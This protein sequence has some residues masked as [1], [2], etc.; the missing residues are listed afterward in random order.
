MYQ[1]LF[2]YATNSCEKSTEAYREIGAQ[3][4]SFI[5]HN[6][7]AVVL[8]AGTS[9]VSKG[10]NIDANTKHYMNFKHSHVLKEANV[11]RDK[12]ET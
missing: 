5:Y 1:N 10:V 9:I 3:N 12:H 4:Q 6:E 7:A 11:L 2:S 8:L